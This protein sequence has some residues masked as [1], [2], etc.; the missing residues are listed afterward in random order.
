[1]TVAHICT[2]AEEEEGISHLPSGLQVHNSVDPKVTQWEVASRFHLGV[3][4]A[5]PGLP[6]GPAGS[7]LGG[8]L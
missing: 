3:F 8:L 2:S 1:M 5:V 6:Y 7:R 4:P